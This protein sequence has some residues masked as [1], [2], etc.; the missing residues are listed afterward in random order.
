MGRP[1]VIKR[2]VVSYMD[3]AAPRTVRSGRGGT[4]VVPG[5]LDRFFANIRQDGD[6]WIWTKTLTSKG[7][8]P[9]YLTS[10]YY[11]MAHR[12][13]YELLRTEIPEGL[14]LDHL[15]RVHSCVNPWHLE[16]VTNREN[17]RRGEHPHAGVAFRTNT[18]PQGHD[19]SDAYVY[20]IGGTGRTARR[21]RPCQRVSFAAYRERKRAS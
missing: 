15:C 19:L 2:P 20:R 17:Q 6:C 18:C 16:P 7:Y 14:L 4:R 13:I 8:A 9:F 10:T 3:A 5:H 12:W 21:C 1:A 11:V